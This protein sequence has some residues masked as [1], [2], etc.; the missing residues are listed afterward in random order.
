MKKRQELVGEERVATFKKLPECLRRAFKRTD[1]R[2][3]SESLFGWSILL[4]TDVHF[5]DRDCQFR[6]AETSLHSREPRFKCPEL[7]LCRL[8][9]VSIRVGIKAK[10][11]KRNNPKRKVRMNTI[12]DFIQEPRHL[13]L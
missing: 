7:I 11:A 6:S 10:D 4:P 2:V 1:H 12:L 8:L 13:T 5:C 9:V 3:V